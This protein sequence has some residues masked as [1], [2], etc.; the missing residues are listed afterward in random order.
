MTQ[1]TPTSTYFTAAQLHTLYRIGDIMIPAN[2]A[3]P[4]FSATQGL[5]HIDAVM[6]PANANDI[7]D[8]ALLLSI[9]KFMPNFILAG[10]IKLS[11]KANSLPEVIAPLFRMLD[12]ALRGIIYTIYYANKTGANYQ[13]KT[14]FSAID[15]AVHCEPDGGFASGNFSKI[16]DIVASSA[17]DLTVV[18]TATQK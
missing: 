10:L 2:G 12:I 15:Y 3:F 5:E 1:Q 17:A 14:A 18:D 11:V 16:E 9:L 4:K 6:A 8:L 13:G 7:K